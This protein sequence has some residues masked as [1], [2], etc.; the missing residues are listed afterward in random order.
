MWVTIQMKA[1]QQYIRVVLLKCCT[2]DPNVLSL[3]MKLFPYE[4][5]N[6]SY[7][8]I[9]FC[10]YICVFHYS[11]KYHLQKVSFTESII[12][13]LIW[14]MWSSQLLNSLVSTPWQLNCHV[15]TTTLIGCSE[16]SMQWDSCNREINKNKNLWL[17]Y[18]IMWQKQDQ[19]NSLNVTGLY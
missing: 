2:S 16:V 14:P 19:F 5:S 17:Y 1:K 9:L 6:E 8:A 11:A 18:L 4:H 7:H 15:N 13:C 12:P 3:W 10:A